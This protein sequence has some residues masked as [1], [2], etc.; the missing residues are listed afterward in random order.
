MRTAD[1]LWAV[2]MLETNTTESIPDIPDWKEF[3]CCGLVASTFGILGIFDNLL[4]IFLIRRTEKLRT[5]CFILIGGH[6]CFCCIM[7]IGFTILGMHYL[8]L[9]LGFLTAVYTRIGCTFL[10][11]TT[12]FSSPPSSALSF[13][14]AIERVI[15]IAFPVAYRNHD[16]RWTKLALALSTAVGVLCVIAAIATI[17]APWGDLTKCYSMFSGFDLNYSVFF[18]YFNLGFSILA[19]LSYVVM[20]I[21]IRVKNQSSPPGI[22]SHSP[23]TLEINQFMKKQ[24]KL[25]PMVNA[26]GIAYALFGVGP[27]L[28]AST[29]STLAD[30]QY[31]QRGS[32]YVMALKSALPSLDF[33]V[34]TWKCR[35]F[36]HALKSMLGI[37]NNQVQEI[38]N[39]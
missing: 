12:T 3:L 37:K 35:E 31:L 2:N 1:H 14:I 6:A 24:M 10:Y 16:K 29:F 20:C 27:P 25:L 13:L 7:A 34:L 18:T 28:L 9:G 36:R 23:E 22:A 38:G 26:L 19:V 30:G 32:L 11:T 8:G 5:S 33:C 21:Y 4:T 39:S 17:S 15:A